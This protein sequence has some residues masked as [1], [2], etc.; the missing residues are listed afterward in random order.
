MKKVCDVYF[1]NYPME[2]SAMLMLF[3]CFFKFGLTKKY[4]RIIGLNP[5]GF[6]EPIAKIT[7]QEPQKLLDL[8]ILR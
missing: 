8:L 4:Y 3:R 1:Q 5:M 2:Q 6:Q 7:N